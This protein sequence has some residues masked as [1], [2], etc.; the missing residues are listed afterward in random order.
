MTRQLTHLIFI[1]FYFLKEMS[2]SEL[3]Q[4]DVEVEDKKSDEEMEV[5]VLVNFDPME[6]VNTWESTRLGIT[7][8][9]IKAIFFIIIHHHYIIMIAILMIFDSVL[10][11]LWCLIP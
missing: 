10:L 4:E 1:T 2:D 11:F 8:I 7:M 6:K 3:S 5:D 9:T